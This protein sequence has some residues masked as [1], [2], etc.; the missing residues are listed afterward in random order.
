MVCVHVWCY[1]VSVLCALCVTVIEALNCLNITSHS[2]YVP[3]ID[4]PHHAIKLFSPKVSCSV[5]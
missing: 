1:C 3:F 2:L 5:I 4:T